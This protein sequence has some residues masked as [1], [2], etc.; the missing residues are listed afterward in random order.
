MIYTDA[1]LKAA[2]DPYIY[3]IK[4]GDDGVVEFYLDN[5]MLQTFRACEARGWLDFVE[6]Y[7]NSG[8]V[9]FLDF[10]TVVHD[11]MELYYVNRYTSNFDIHNFCLNDVTNAWN[12]REMDY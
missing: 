1:L 5:H 12:D 4:M 6:G 10:G 2:E 11:L 3:W 9:W 8:R 7:L